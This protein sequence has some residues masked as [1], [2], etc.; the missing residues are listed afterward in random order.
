MRIVSD[1]TQ[2][3]AAVENARES[4][5][6]DFVKYML[7]MLPQIYLDFATVGKEEV[8]EFDYGFYQTYVDEEWY[9]SVRRGIERLM[10][11]DDT[12]LETFEQDMKYSDTPIAASVSESLADIYQP[13]YNFIMIVRE[14]EGSELVGAYLECHENFETY[15]SQ[16][17]CNVLRALNNI[18]YGS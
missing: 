2:Y 10:G 3:C 17:L 6:E 13:L 16:T 1:A 9:E 12:F 4:E 7:R 15:W 18:R 11:P 14:T 8:G 5:K